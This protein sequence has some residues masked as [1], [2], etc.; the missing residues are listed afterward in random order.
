[1]TDV[2]RLIDEDTLT[3]EQTN[4][5]FYKRVAKNLETFRKKEDDT[6]K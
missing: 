4:R 2:D 3:E 6:N 1:V 5:Q